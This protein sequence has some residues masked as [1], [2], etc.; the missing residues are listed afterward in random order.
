M[1]I[2]VF[3]ATGATGQALLTAA[4]QAHHT[5][6]A[7]V[8]DAGRLGTTHADRIVTGSVFDPGTVQ[9]AL[10]DADAAVIAFGLSG[11]RRV[12]LY[13]QGT[14]VIVDAMHK[15]SVRRLIVVSEA[16]GQHSSGILPRAIAAVYGLTARSAMR[17]RR[18]QDATV[19]SSDLDWTF[20]RPIIVTDGPARGLPD[21]PLTPHRTLS[22]TTYNDLAAAIL[23]ALSDPTTFNHH[24]YP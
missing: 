7:H 17:Q 1:K 24:L 16:Y 15:Q 11:D 14:E 20:V 22:R 19:L 5:V 23:K 8:R 3:G 21:K 12:P 6:T 9:D 2:T 13:S 10:T 18:V 4:A